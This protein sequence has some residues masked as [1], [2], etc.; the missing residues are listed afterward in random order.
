[1]VI[2]LVPAVIHSDSLAVTDNTGENTDYML[3]RHAALKGYAV[4]AANNVILFPDLYYSVKD[5]FSAW[6]FIQWAIVFF[7][8]ALGTLDYHNVP[9]LTKKRHHTHA[10]VGVNNLTVA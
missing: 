2:K 6:S 5:I 7:K 4:V 10:H 1:M 3:V 8:S 9:V